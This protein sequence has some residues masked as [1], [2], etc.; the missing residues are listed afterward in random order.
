MRS[1][2]ITNFGKLTSNLGKVRMKA[3]E[4]YNSSEACIDSMETLELK[5]GEFLNEG[6][7]EASSN[8]ALKIQNG[9]NKG[10]LNIHGDF[11]IESSDFFENSGHV[12][13][14][15]RSTVKAKRLS[16][17]GKWDF[18]GATKIEADEFLYNSGDLRLTQSLTL[19]SPEFNNYGKMA[20]NHSLSLQ[21]GKTKNFGQLDVGQHLGFSL[22][23]FFNDQK[24]HI[25]VQGITK[26]THLN[27]HNKGEWQANGG[28]F[29]KG[30]EFI[31]D[32]NAIMRVGNIW[33]SH[34]E[35]SVLSGHIDSGYLTLLDSKDIRFTGSL[36]SSALQV[37]GSSIVCD[38]AAAFDITHHLGLNAMKNLEFNSQILLRPYAPYEAKPEFEELSHQ[39]LSLPKGVFL[40]AGSS[41]RK[42]GRVVAEKGSVLML[43]QGELTHVGVTE[44]GLEQNDA[45]QLQAAKMLNIAGYL[46]AWGS[47][48]FESEENISLSSKSEAEAAS[49]SLRAGSSISCE[50]T[51]HTSGLL[52]VTAGENVTFASTAKVKAQSANLIAKNTISSQGTFRIEEDFLTR[53]NFFRECFLN[54]VSFDRSGYT[55][56]KKGLTNADRKRKTLL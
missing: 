2:K 8:A 39:I 43:S 17:L 56:L 49:L 7:I 13:G 18:E 55:T 42:A 31:S 20:V 46:K 30:K 24:G 14:M 1:K 19:Q 33:K 21:G 37:S 40:R 25:S 26:G 22:E 52:G 9:D 45:L 53:S 4:F 32:R 44:S 35:K 11:E 5:L 47:L 28:L 54:C 34:S 27:F 6:T 10:L 16:N 23:E 3:D 41:L 48:G 36:H 38:L 12:R 51:L 50:G 15:Q 29:S